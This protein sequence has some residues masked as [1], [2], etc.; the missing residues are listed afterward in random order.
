MIVLYQAG[1]AGDFHPVER[2]SSGEESR[3]AFANAARL[4]ESRGLQEAADLLQSIPFEVW[5]AVNTFN[6]EFTVLLAKVAAARYGELRLLGAK[7]GVRD[8]FSQIARALGALLLPDSGLDAP[9]R[10]DPDAGQ[11][12]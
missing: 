7:P 12:R 8:R 5:K 9:A 1:G 6:N 11:P 3:Q 10:L 2:S 4:L